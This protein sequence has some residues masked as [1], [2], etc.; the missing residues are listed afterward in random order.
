[1]LLT[2]YQW[3]LAVQDT[4]GGVLAVLQALDVTGKDVT[5]RHVMSGVNPQGVAVHSFKHR[6]S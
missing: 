2:D 5:I 6:K 1:M 4:W 3:R